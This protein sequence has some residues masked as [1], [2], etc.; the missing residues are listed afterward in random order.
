VKIT[1]KK[2]ITSSSENPISSSGFRIFM[3]ILSTVV[4]I[5]TIS[6]FIHFKLHHGKEGSK[7]FDSM[8]PPGSST[9]DEFK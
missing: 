6:I 2:A 1:K 9:F 5:L 4:F 7:E 3:A 8:D